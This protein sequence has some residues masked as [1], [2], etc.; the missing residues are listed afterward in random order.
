MD[1]WSP[2]TILGAGSWGT[3]LALLLANSGQSV[4]LWGHNPDHMADMERERRN[5]RYLPEFLLPETVSLYTDLHAAVADIK[6]VVIMVPSHAFSE[7]LS[8]L[9]LS[10]SPQARI[11]WGTKGLD[12]QTHELLHHTARRILSAQRPYAVISGPTFARE[13]A[14][15]LPTAVTLASAH[16]GFRHALSQRLNQNTFRVY[17]SDDIT[18]VE[19]CGVVK[20]ILAIAAG[21]IDTLGLGSNALSAMITRGLAEM[22]RLGVALGGKPA[23]FTG[24]AGIGDLVLT[25]TDNQ[26]RNRRFGKAIAAGQTQEAATAQIGQIVEGFHNLKTVYELAQRL[27][28]SMPITTQVYH[29]VYQGLSVSAAIHNL[30]AR[31]TRS[32]D[33]S[34]TEL[35]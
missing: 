26:S 24:L 12:P 33:D 25:C 6:D 17:T 21:I 18:G 4:R 3:A 16:K 29:V 34:N 1:S 2:I 19:V 27:K 30:F 14:K 35:F 23:T 7:T 9:S 10:L 15:G 11:A 31:Q 32:E 22:K 8:Q 20:N 5:V 13:V 28:V